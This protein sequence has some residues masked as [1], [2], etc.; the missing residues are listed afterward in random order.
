MSALCNL[1]FT[2]QKLVMQ[3]IL[4]ESFAEFHLRMVQH[5][6]QPAAAF[7]PLSQHAEAR[8]ANFS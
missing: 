1:A 6:V 3:Q 4:G 5:I 8:P 2:D 7:N